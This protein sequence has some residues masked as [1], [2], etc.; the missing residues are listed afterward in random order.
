MEPDVNELS[1]SFA[2]AITFATIQHQRHS[3]LHTFPTI[4]VHPR[5]VDIIIY[6]SELDLLMANY[7]GWTYKSFLFLW[8]VLNH[9]IF[10]FNDL[11]QYKNREDYKCG[12]RSL[13]N[14]F[15]VAQAPPRYGVNKASFEVA[16]ESFKRD[17]SEI[18]YG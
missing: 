15:G 18:F 3:E 5:G 4:R 16:H 7:Y 10:S 6:N 1:Q 8:M 9:K 13:A 14:Q 17:E 11:S 12:Y 2:T